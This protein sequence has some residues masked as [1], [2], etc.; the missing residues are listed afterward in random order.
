MRKRRL[1]LER[2]V[3]EFS[4]YTWE[5]LVTHFATLAFFLLFFGFA[6]AMGGEE[7]PV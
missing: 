5:E 3:D 4:G 6:F 1:V 7:E 2:R